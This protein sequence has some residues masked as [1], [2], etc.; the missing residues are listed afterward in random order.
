M[1]IYIYMRIMKIYRYRGTAAAYDVYTAACAD[2]KMKNNN[3]TARRCVISDLTRN[4]KKIT[5]ITAIIPPPP[6]QQRWLPTVEYLYY[7][8]W[9][10]PCAA[11]TDRNAHSDNNYYR[12]ITLYTNIYIIY[13][14]GKS[15]YT[16]L[17]FSGFLRHYN[18]NASCYYIIIV[19]RRWSGT[20]VGR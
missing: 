8:N 18:R 2:M 3:G 20:V 10:I 11:D 7:F 4:K 1:Y 14:P 13:I 17:L 5:M 16:R 15:G 9:Y 19:Y 6:L 12:C